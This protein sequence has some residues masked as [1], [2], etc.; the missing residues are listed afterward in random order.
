MHIEHAIVSR[1]VDILEA[2]IVAGDPGIVD[3][4]IDP[5]E[6]TDHCGNRLADGALVGNVAARGEGAKAARGEPGRDLA[7]AV[8][9]D[10]EHAH[11]GALLGQEHGGSPA[12]PARR[13]GNDCDALR[14]LCH[15]STSRYIP[16]ASRTRL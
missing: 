5:A 14:Q 9:V 2:G 4:H 16:T 15:R 1:A 8:A 11:R 7:G 3:Q 6:G 10:I 12:D 13:S